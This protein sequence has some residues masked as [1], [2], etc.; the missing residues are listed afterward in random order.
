MEGTRSKSCTIWDF[1]YCASPNSRIFDS[2]E[3]RL[4]PRILAV[5]IDRYEPLSPIPR[6]LLALV[7]YS[8]CPLVCFWLTQS[9]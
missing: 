8:L 3:R 7:D 9:T 6:A 1:G 2:S 5:A 4:G